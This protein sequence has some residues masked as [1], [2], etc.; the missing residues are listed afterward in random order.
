[1]EDP[2]FNDEQF[3]AVAQDEEEETLTTSEERQTPEGYI[4]LLHAEGTHYLKIGRTTNL[5]RRLSAIQTHCPHRL[6]VLYAVH[7][8]D[9]IAMERLL[10]TQFAQYRTIGEWFAMPL[11]TPSV[12]ALLGA[13]YRMISNDSEDNSSQTSPPSPIWE[14]SHD[15]TAILEYLDTHGEGTLS[16][17]MVALNIHEDEAA[18]FRVRLGR[19]Y[20][21][22]LIGRRGWGVYFAL[23]R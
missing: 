5:E 20:K 11:D 4:Y 22:C 9:S 7:C 19:L 1:V 21:K 12:L 16:D 14:R 13:F 23:K 2:V 17:M 15:T 8:R 3:D 6:V 18:K 10:H